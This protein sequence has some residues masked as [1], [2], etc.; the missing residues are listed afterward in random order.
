MSADDGGVA[1]RGSR[2]QA[3]EWIHGTRV[4][5]SLFQ[6]MRET[7]QGTYREEPMTRLVWKEGF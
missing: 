2:G 7:F 3:T 1:V 5:T 6:N 4:H